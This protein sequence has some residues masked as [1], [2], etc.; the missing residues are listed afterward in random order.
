MFY[1]D[2][3]EFPIDPSYF[4]Y[5]FAERENPV[6]RIFTFQGPSRTQINLGFFGR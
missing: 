1:N 2:L 4:G 5:N 6:L 3:W